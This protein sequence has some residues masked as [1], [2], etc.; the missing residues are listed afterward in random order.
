MRRVRYSWATGFWYERSANRLW[1]FDR[2]AHRW[3]FV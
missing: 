2:G 3:D 1:F